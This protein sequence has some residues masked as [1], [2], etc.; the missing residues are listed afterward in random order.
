MLYL[1]LDYSVFNRQVKKSNKK[2]A[3]FF[4]II[5]YII[6]DFIITPPSIEILFPKSY[7]FL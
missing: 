1:F 3:I 5:I 2:N 7:I 4:D 6:H